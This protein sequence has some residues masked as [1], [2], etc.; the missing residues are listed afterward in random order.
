MTKHAIWPFL[1][2]AILALTGCGKSVA[3]SE[4]S[5]KAGNDPAEQGASEIEAKANETVKS[6]ISA[7]ETYSG[8]QATLI[9][10]AELQKQSEKSEVTL[11]EKKK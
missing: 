9:A 3:L 2:V 5:A 1:M 4:D 8:K 6:K 11:L 10:E 7:L